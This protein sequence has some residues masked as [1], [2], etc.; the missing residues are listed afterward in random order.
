MDTG[1]A[2]VSPE[3]ILGAFAGR[4]EPVRTPTLYRVGILL[5]T[6]GMVLLPVIYA[7]LIA[8]LGYLV[9]Y[10]ATHHWVLFT[11]I[12]GSGRVWIVK[13]LLYLGPIFAGVLAVVFMIKPLFSRPPRGP[14]PYRLSRDDEPLLFTFVERICSIVGAPVPC[15]IRVDNQVNASAAFR[16]GLFSMFGNDLVLTIGL[17]N[18]AVVRVDRPRVPLVRSWTPP[19]M[20][21]PAITANVHFRN[22]SMPVITEA[23]TT[24]PATTATGEATESKKLSSQGM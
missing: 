5:V 22:G 21:P 14:D 6:L 11:E 2:G 15:E 16:R 10:H 9:Y 1:N 13:L 4:I 19:A 7:A 12:G 24:T 20:P 23:E 8:A 3:E 17:P 18:P